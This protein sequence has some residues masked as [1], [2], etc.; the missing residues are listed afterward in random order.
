MRVRDEAHRFAVSRHRRRRSKRTLSSRLD[1]IPGI[2]PKRRKLL[3][4]RFGSVDG[5]RQAGLAELQAAL[6]AKVGERVYEAL[7]PE[8]AAGAEPAPEAS[9]GQSP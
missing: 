9:E 5:A 1:E 3:V 6:G 4:Q 2:G 8:A 7:R